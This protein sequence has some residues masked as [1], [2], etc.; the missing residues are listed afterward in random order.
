MQTNDGVIFFQ[1]IREQFS[2]P[3]WQEQV[4]WDD[5]CFVLDQH[6]LLEF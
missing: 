4:Q 6:F 1:Y 2:A 3:P 5:V